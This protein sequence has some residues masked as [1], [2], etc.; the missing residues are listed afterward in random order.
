MNA[1]FVAG[2]LAALDDLD[3]P[4]LSTAAAKAFAARP[5]VFDPVTILVPALASLRASGEAVAIAILWEHCAAFLLQRSGCPPEAPRDWRQDVKLSCSCADCRELQKFTLD[6]VAQDARF[7]VRQ[8]RRQHLHQQIER[9]SLDMTHVTERKGSPQTLVCTKDRR[10]YQRRCEQYRKDI[11]A[12][13]SLAGQAYNGVGSEE[14]L[15]GIESARSLA[16]Q[17]SPA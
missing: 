13:V 8:D 15:T 6:P 12:L 5:A 1:A 16:G 7:R 17:W 2:L 3:S 11:A 10:S 14:L 9:H 4:A